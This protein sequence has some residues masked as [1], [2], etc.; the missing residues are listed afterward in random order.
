MVA[1]HPESCPMDLQT[2]TTTLRNKVGTSSDLGATLKFDC[3]DE[4]VI[5]I[6]GASSPSTVDNTDRDTDC[7]ITLSVDT[8]GEMMSGEL[9]P[10][11]A[12][13]SGRIKVSGD[14][15]VALKLQSV[16]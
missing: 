14:M 8:L 6:D 16:F 10:T 5:V 2:A 12:F 3:G 13:M 4:G 9:N 11:T 1:P 15:G 7:T